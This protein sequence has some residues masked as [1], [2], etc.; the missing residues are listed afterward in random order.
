V[1]KP[2][3]GTPVPQSIPA[4]VQ[5]PNLVRTTSRNRP[6]KSPKALVDA[7][8]PQHVRLPEP[9][10][11]CRDLVSKLLRHKFAHPFREPVDYVKLNLP[12][13]PR[14]IANPMDLGTIQ[15]RL[16]LGFYQDVDA[17]ET[18]VQ[19]VWSNARTYNPPGQPV[20][21]MAVELKRVFDEAM[22]KIPQPLAE[23]LRARWRARAASRSVAEGA[24]AAEAAAAAPRLARR[25][26]R[27]WPRRL[28]SSNA[29]S[30]SSSS[31]SSSKSS[32]AAAAA[33]AAG[34]EAEVEAV[35]VV[36]AGAAAAAAA[37]AGGG[38]RTWTMCRCSRT[39]R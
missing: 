8:K 27:A 14:V 25:R 15:K 18:D 38:G 32:R 31:S 37:A 7:D 26:W 39:R 11:R 12:D 4:S 36:A 35:A 21:E 20:H 23:A 16:N 6:V 10:R 13:Y 5:T 19:L 30:S 2:E 33:A 28:R 9:L 3:P 22:A 34:A 29:L 17:F 1:P 24:E